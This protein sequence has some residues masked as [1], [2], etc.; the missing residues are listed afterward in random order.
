MIAF[1][2]LAMTAAQDANATTIGRCWA[3]GVQETRAAALEVLQSRHPPRR[4]ER[5]PRP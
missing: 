4:G 1:S 3:G 2:T 5:E